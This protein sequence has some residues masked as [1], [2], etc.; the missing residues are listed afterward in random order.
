MRKV[1]TVRAPP[2]VLVLDVGGTHVK[3][4][5]PGLAP[6][7][8]IPSGPTMTP[9]KMMR[10]LRK[11][12]RGVKYD[13]VTVGYPGLVA[14]G[15]IVREPA[16]LG[17]GWIGFDFERALGRPTRI[18]NDA[19]LQALGSYRGGSMLFLGLGTGLGSAMI[20]AGELQPMELA[21]LPWKKGK[22]YEEYV[23]ESAL[24]RLGRKKWRQ[25]VFDVIQ[26]F[27][28]ALEPEYIVLGGGNARK[29]KDLP[30]GVR[31]GNNRDALL[32]G[33]RIWSGPRG[34]TT[35][36]VPPRDPPRRVDDRVSPDRDV[37]RKLSGGR[38]V[39]EPN[40]SAHRPYQARGEPTVP[41]AR[42]P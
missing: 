19:A 10:Q 18:I 40:G 26:A 2:R 8:T 4:Y 35:A 29:L 20:L 22:T 41:G 14:H 16:H 12:L 15:R 27:S 34:I 32:G 17:K 37:R 39:Q 9:E 13:T 21:H 30:A 7:E 25:E 42:G 23:G 31:R 33:R 5:P 6:R 28:A 36:R 38:A 24:K 3:A 1:R 11:R